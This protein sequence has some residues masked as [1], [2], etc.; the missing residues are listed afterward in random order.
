MI[1]KFRFLRDRFAC[2]VPLADK[3]FVDVDVLD[4]AYHTENKE[5]ADFLIKKS[6]E[7]GSLVISLNNV[8]EIIEVPQSSQ[9]KVK[10]GARSSTD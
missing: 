10:A 4:G 7:V 2:R 9:P 5:V 1:Y 3:S 6:K 8:N